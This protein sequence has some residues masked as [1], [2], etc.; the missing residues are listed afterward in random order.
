MIGRRR[1]LLQL[2]A[3]GWRTVVVVVAA[4]AA[5]FMLTAS[6]AQFRGPEP[7]ADRLASRDA[8]EPASEPIAARNVNYPGIAA[9]PLF[10][11]SRTPW[12]PPPPEPPP[13][14]QVA[15][16]ALESYHLVGV[17]LS[18]GLRTALVRAQDKKTVALSEGQEFEGWKLQAITE[19]RLHFAAG[20]ST[21]DMVRRKP[22][23]MQK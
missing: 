13:P 10:Y 4:V 12:R 6:P 2:G 3:F 14:A 20:G 16:S 11:P 9:R 18:D 21:F 5:V 22:S 23:E 17:V 15:P 8:A 19:D 1:R 7:A